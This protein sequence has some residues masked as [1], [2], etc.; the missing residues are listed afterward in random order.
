M[1]PIEPATSE[2]ADAIDDG[3][4]KG[5]RLI[6][7][8]NEEPF[9]ECLE[10]CKVLVHGNEKLGLNEGIWANSLLPVV[11]CPGAQRCAEF[12]YARGISYQ[13]YRHT[14]GA[15]WA[16]ATR[17]KNEDLGTYLDLAR[18]EI[19][20]H[21]A[22]DTLD[23]VR[24]HVSGDFDT[25]EYIH[26]WREVAEEYPDVVF[27]G[28]TRS[29]RVG[30]LL[31]HLNELR[32]VDNVELWA[33]VD[34]G[35]ASDVH[36]ADERIPDWRWALV[37]EDEQLDGRMWTG[38]HGIDRKGVACPKQTG[39]KEH[40]ADCGYCFGGAAGGNGSSGGGDLALIKH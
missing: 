9:E 31:E 17:I 20:T 39:H 22:S 8:I 12:C 16:R 26:G 5:Q 37:V 25:P 33:S 4:T 40:C 36:A 11:T 15:A 30:G 14:A 21:L 29:W 23:T 13:R 35:I 7:E 32:S 28:Y 10:N 6:E 1:D 34:R 27:F 3:M 2:I 19:D 38:E 18:E 24:W